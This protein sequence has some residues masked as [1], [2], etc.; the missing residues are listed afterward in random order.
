MGVSHEVK[1]LEYSPERSLCVIVQVK[2]QAT[3][4]LDEPWKSWKFEELGVS[5]Q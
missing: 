4:L 1:M 5:R 3:Q 2:M